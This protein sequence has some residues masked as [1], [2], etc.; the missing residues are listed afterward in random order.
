MNILII[1]INNYLGNK[2]KTHFLNLNNDV[3]S[4][5]RKEFVSKIKD[6]SHS[7]LSVIIGDLI[8]E[9][10]SRP[11]PT[12]LDVAYYF[13]NYTSERGNIYKDLEILSLQN[14][15]KKLRRRHCKHLIYVVPLTSPVNDAIEALL[16][17]SYINYTII[18]TSNII[19]KD[20]ALMK[21]FKS[22][23]SKFAIISNSR[24]AESKCQPIALNDVL[25]YLW[26]TA[27][28]PLAFNKTFDIGG[29]EVLTYREMIDQ[30]LKVTKKEKKVITLPYIHPKLSSL[31]LSQSGDI[32]KEMATAFSANIQDDIICKN[33]AIKE[34]FPHKDLPFKE[35]LQKALN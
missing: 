7:R 4:L 18:R 35:A 30:Y 3:T 11:F 6:K 31:W 20:S 22:L 23:S 9:R 33:T 10:Y 34:I 25:D 28:N 26:F 15:I 29:P 1:G 21:I 13:S 12:H 17:M 27:G 19:G 2:A 32:S 14:Y 8:R 24:F 5:V 16:K